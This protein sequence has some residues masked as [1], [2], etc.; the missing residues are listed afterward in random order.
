MAV[1]QNK[2]RYLNH[3]YY[4][5][6]QT[7]DGKCPR[8]LLNLQLYWHSSIIFSF[9]NSG[10]S[11]IVPIVLVISPGLDLLLNAYQ[12]KALGWNVWIGRKQTDRM[13]VWSQTPDMFR[14]CK[15][16]TCKLSWI[17]LGVPL[18]VN[19]DPRN[20]QVNLTPLNSLCHLRKSSYRTLPCYIVPTWFVHMWVMLT[21]SVMYSVSNF[22][23]TTSHYYA[24]YWYAV[25]QYLSIIDMLLTSRMNWV[26]LC[27]PWR[28]FL[29]RYV[30]IYPNRNVTREL[31]VSTCRSFR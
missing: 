11:C 19:R 22:T 2:I 9:V 26:K 20:I 28:N 31:C 12:K 21:F 30:T 17:F 27:T 24:C 1:Q 16:L 25:N 7:L 23:T 13:R 6:P 14:V 3:V 5:V 8:R 15:I 29:R 4:V 18:K 10:E